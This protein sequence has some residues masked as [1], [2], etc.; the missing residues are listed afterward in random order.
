VEEIGA[1]VCDRRIFPRKSGAESLKGFEGDPVACEG[2][3]RGVFFAFEI[4]QKLPG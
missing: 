1:K 3:G 4:A 2:V